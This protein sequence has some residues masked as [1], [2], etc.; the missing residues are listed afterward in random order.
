MNR[1]PATEALASLHGF[2]EQQ[3]RKIPLLLA[4][5]QVATLER[6][7]KVRQECHSKMNLSSLIDFF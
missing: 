5:R 3:K 7:N 4:S 6:G 2:K 1:A